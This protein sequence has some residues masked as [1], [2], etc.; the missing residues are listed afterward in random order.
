[1]SGRNTMNRASNSGPSNTGI[2][3]EAERL[4]R[5]LQHLHLPVANVTRIMRQILPQHAKVTDDMK[6]TVPQLVTRFIHHITKKANERCQREQRRTVT[7]EDVLWAMNKIGLTN[8]VG[9]LTLYLHKYREQEAESSLNSRKSNNVRP[10][11]ELALAPP[12][13]SASVFPINCPPMPTYSY[14]YFPPNGLF[15]DHAAATMRGFNMN[16]R[17]EMVVNDDSPAESSSSS[18][19]SNY[20]LPGINDP[21]GQ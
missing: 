4:S 18:S 21:Y 19:S 5:R 2:D 12:I 6:E 17:N 11:F 7:A 16:F 20:G 9:P 14:P 8:Y 3:T 10:N 1:M 13:G 15:Y